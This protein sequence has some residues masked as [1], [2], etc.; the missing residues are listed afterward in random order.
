M[1]TNQAFCT[2]CGAMLEANDTFCPKCGAQ[3]AEADS[4]YR[5]KAAPQGYAYGNMSLEKSRAESKTS[6]VMILSGI[7]LVFAVI[8]IIGCFSFGSAVQVFEENPELLDDMGLTMEDVLALADVMAFV[9]YIFL[10][11]LVMIII[12]MYFVHKK[13]NFTVS[14][15]LYALGSAVLFGAAAIGGLSEMILAIIGLLVTYLLY[16]AKPAFS[17]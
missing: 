4:T 5:G 12:G 11:S 16:T 1:D 17:S 13:E 6:K 7:Y 2:Q 8:M 9:G 15:V 14:V 3:V 10:A